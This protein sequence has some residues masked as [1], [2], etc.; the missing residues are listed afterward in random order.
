MICCVNRTG[1][2]GEPLNKNLNHKDRRDLIADIVAALHDPIELCQSHGLSLDDLGEW[3][4]D[5]KNQQALSGICVLSDLQAQILLS[6]YRLHAAGRLIKLATEDSPEVS[7][8]VARRAC[9]DLLKMDLKRA[10]FENPDSSRGAA[11]KTT[12]PEDGKLLRRLL[13]D[14]VSQS[15]TVDKDPGVSKSK[16]TASTKAKA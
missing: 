3:I 10:D 2:C 4:L 16:K 5:P 9:V 1:F 14:A 12:P 11:E 8:D 6:R 13:Y 15:K 7:R